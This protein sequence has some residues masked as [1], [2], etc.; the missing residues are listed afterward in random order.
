LSIY[1]NYAI[2]ED[3]RYVLDQEKIWQI[4]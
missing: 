4:L 2:F 1:M 3:Y